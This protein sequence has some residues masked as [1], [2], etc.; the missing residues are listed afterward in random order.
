MVEG[1][2]EGDFEGGE[3]MAGGGKLMQVFVTYI[4]LA[5]LPCCYANTTTLSS[6]RQATYVLACQYKNLGTNN[7]LASNKRRSTKLMYKIVQQL[8]KSLAKFPFFFVP[9]MIQKK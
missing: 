5:F 7:F 2:L 9:E 6:I 1:V 3:G 8:I 4:P